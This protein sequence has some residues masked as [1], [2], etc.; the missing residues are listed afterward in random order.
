MKKVF[1]HSC[2]AYSN[3]IGEIKQKLSAQIYTP[4]Q[5]RTHTQTQTQTQ[6]P[7]HLEP[8]N[9]YMGKVFAFVL[10]IIIKGVQ[11]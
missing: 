3:N 1:V 4:T 6:E 2:L 8:Q 11:D 5:T 10:G 9:N 7:T